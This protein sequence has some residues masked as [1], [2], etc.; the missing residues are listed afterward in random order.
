[1]QVEVAQLGEW[2]AVVAEAEPVRTPMGTPVVSRYEKLA[3]E[4]AEDVARHGPDPTVKTTMFSLQASYLDFGLRV[5]REVLEENTAAI[6]PQDLFVQRPS[7]EPLAAALRALWGESG[8]DRSAFRDLL[9]RATLRQVMAS[10]TA[11]Q[12]LR[13]AVLGWQVVS[14]PSD[15]APLTLGACGRHFAALQSRVGAGEEPPASARHLPTGMDD[16]YCAGRCCA[17]GAGP[18][19][20]FPARCALFPLLDKLRRR[21]AFPEETEKG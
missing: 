13:S 7:K 10:M 19:G 8:L 2:W 18:D 6:W 15:L 20:D 17:P 14:T 3:R 16:A 21:A 4:V 1:M 12:V 11:G 5:R 9:R